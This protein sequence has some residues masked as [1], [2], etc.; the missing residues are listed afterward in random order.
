MPAAKSAK[1]GS[2]KVIDDEIL[3]ALTAAAKEIADGSHSDSFIVPAVQGGA[4]TSIN[5]NV[6]EI[7]TNLAL[8]STGKKC[9]T[10]SYI[11]PTEHANIYQSTND[12]IPTALT[13]AAIASC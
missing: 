9:G 2:L 7:I 4:G 13:I 3:D 5:M 1:T 8:L 10:Y 12:V 11:D 6:N